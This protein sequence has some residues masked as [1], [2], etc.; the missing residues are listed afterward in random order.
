MPIPPEDL[1]CPDPSGCPVAVDELSDLAA[2]G[3]LPQADMDAD[4]D[5]FRVYDARDGY[6]EPNPGF[7]DTRFAP[8]DDADGVR[9]PTFY[10]ADSLA[11]ALLETSLHDVTG[12]KPRL[13]SEHA[14]LG[15]HHA[16]LV[17]PEPLR[18]ADLRDSSLQTLNI[19]RQAAVT[20]SQE[21][22]PCTRRVAKAMHSGPQQAA[23][24]MWH[25]RQAELNG[26]PA[27]VTA[28]LFCD[29]VPVHRGAWTLAQQPGASGPLLEGHGRLILD[30][31]AVE[32]GVTIVDE[33]L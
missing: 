14:L 24:I 28:V 15:K 32:L 2:A 29:R 9:V 27:A 17:P 21:H 25:S 20:S 12:M 31:L 6:A 1:V 7:G 23:G 22:Y 3:N 16:R 33:G 18:L 8:F 13:V 10:A 26:Q 5:W 4:H 19:P 30:K 11:A